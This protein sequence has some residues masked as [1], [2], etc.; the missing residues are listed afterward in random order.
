MQQLSNEYLAWH[1]LY[2]YSSSKAL[3]DNFFLRASDYVIFSHSVISALFFKSKLSKHFLVICD[4]TYYTPG[5]HRLKLRL[6]DHYYTH[7]YR[8]WAPL[9]VLFPCQN[10]IYLKQIPTEKQGVVTTMCF[11]CQCN[12]SVA[13]IFFFSFHRKDKCSFGEENIIQKDWTH[14]VMREQLFSV[15][16]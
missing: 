13:A 9:S 2:H 1:F 6:S 8:R 16:S 7:C 14:T 15:P 11:V 5:T 3:M 12:N 4:F 10:L